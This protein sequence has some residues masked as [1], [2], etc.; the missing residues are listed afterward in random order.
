MTEAADL[1]AREE[2]KRE[3]MW[4]PRMRWQ[5]LQQTITW[6]EAQPTVRRNTR[7]C[8]LELQRRKTG[9]GGATQG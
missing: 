6:S 9:G 1:K 8:C 4:N 7:G 5:A 3:R 2:R